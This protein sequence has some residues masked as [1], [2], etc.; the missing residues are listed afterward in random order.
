MAKRLFFNEKAQNEWIKNEIESIINTLRINLS[1][2]LTII[3][4]SKRTNKISVFFKSWT[5][6]IPALIIFE[7]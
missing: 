3:R 4:R 7:K 5:E 6:E 1:K 2:L